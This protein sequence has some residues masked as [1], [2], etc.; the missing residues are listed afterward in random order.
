MVNIEKIDPSCAIGFLLKS[1]RELDEMID[2]LALVKL[3][4]IAPEINTQ[5]RLALQKY[6]LRNNQLLR[7]HYL[8]FLISGK[9]LI[10]Q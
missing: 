2:E 8:R 4:L 7:T 5:F 3:S 10:I 9:R 1:Q 6:T